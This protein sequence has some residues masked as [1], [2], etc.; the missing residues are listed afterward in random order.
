MRL[1]LLLAGDV[2]SNPGPTIREV[3]T[4]F[5]KDG[6]DET[7]WVKPNKS[8]TGLDDF[9]QTFGLDIDRSQPWTLIAKI[10]GLLGR[11]K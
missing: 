3:C 5:E 2:E 7:I 1:L 4:W 6:F 8:K 10:D 11:F 9:S